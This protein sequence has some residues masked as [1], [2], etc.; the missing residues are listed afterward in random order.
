MSKWHREGAPSGRNYK[1]GNP[2]GGG[3]N[4]IKEEEDNQSSETFV[5]LFW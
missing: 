3:A 1:Q 4:N 5:I 2:K